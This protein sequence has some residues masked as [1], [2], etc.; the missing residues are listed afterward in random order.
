MRETWI[1]QT[2]DVIR[3]DI[4]TIAKT[5]TGLTNFKSTGILRGFLEVLSAVVFFIGGDPQ[6][7]MGLSNEAVVDI[8]KRHG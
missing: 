6:S 7:M 1:N 3:D 2:P 4:V 5:N 8:K